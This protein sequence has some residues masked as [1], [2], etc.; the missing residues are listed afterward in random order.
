MHDARLAKR[1]A[2]AFH[3]RTSHSRS[4]PVCLTNKTTIIDHLVFILRNVL[5]RPEHW[6]YSPVLF[7]VFN[8]V[9]FGPVA[10]L[11]Q[12]ASFFFLFFPTKM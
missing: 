1:Q 11:L 3:S 9:F 4:V 7:V 2:V 12:I 6:N 5:T 8:K 10:Q